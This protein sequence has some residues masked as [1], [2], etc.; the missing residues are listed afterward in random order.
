METQLRKLITEQLQ[1]WAHAEIA[2]ETT[3]ELFL[4][5]E[6]IL[7]KRLKQHVNDLIIEESTLF[8]QGILT[9]RHL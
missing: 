9:E 1:R 3:S 6:R 8:W 5:R 2:V 4:K 7:F